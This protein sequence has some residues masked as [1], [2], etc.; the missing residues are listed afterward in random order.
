M[1][2]IYIDIYIYIYMGSLRS[3]EVG[4]LIIV[5][6]GPSYLCCK[7]HAFCWDRLQTIRVGILLPPSGIHLKYFSSADA[8]VNLVIRVSLLCDHY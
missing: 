6:V 1:I 2:R 4:T 7:I 8:F 5:V 3:G